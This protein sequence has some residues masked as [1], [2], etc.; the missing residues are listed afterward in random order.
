MGI[1]SFCAVRGE[2][3]RAE[4]RYGL[5]VI[6]PEQAVDAINERF[7]AHAG[8][9]ALHAKGVLCR[10][11]FTATPEAGALSRAAHMQGEAVPATVRFSNGSGDPGS[12]DYAPDVRGM[13]TKLYLADG[14]RTDIVAQTAPR[15]PTRTPDGFIEFVRAM[16]PGPSQ[17]WK[18]P[19]F[20]ARHPEALAGL[21]ANSVA[22]K[23]PA[24]YATCRYYAIHAFR[25][26]DGNRRERYVRY[27]WLPEAGDESLSRG[28]AKNRG[29]D[30]LQ[31]EIT[32]RLERQPVRFGLELQLASEEDDVNDPTEPWRGDRETILGGTLELTELET[33]RETGG[34]ILVFDPTRVTD[35]IELSDDPILQFRARAYSV[36]IERRSGVSRDSPPA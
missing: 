4:R 9:R 11:A 7:G 3:G 10:G 18:L 12:P 33:E 1:I 13:A 14:S 34:D 2:T 36:S 30:Y 25:W 24:S 8:H 6:T 32:A 15:F 26:I 5:V 19:I 31:E 29:R 22:L 16:T 27:R 35:G 28:E 17:L 23:P 20:L 21:R